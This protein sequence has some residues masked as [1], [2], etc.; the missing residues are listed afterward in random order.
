MVNWTVQSE[1]F[2]TPAFQSTLVGAPTYDPAASH[3]G[4]WWTLF[5]HNKRMIVHNAAI[6]APHP[7]QS[8]WHEWLVDS[9]GVS[10]YGKD[11]P[12]NH[13]SHVYLLG[14]PVLH[15]GVLAAQA[16]FVVLCALYLRY[17]SHPD[18][19]LSR[20][21]AFFG[22]AS[23]CFVVYWLNLLPYIGIARSTFVYHYMPA[24]MYG[25]LLTACTVEA[26]VPR[27]WLRATVLTIAAGL[28]ATL[29]FFGPWIYA[30][31]LTADGHERRRWLPRWN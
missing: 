4:F 1:E 24:L 21:N 17:R 20:F 31:P 15:W 30:T 14:N 11:Y 3:E 26:V 27:K 9:R 28:A 6:L 8:K 16:V 5:S 22:Q 18:M 25:Q 7:W 2:M 19:S 23:F 12:G 29:V 10:Y 13:S